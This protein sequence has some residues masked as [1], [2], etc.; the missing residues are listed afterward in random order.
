MADVVLNSLGVQTWA[1]SFTSVGLNGRWVT[2]ADV[3]L[4]VIT[5]LNANKI[6][7]L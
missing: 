2:F 4:N 7:W 5:L 6:N 1:N 3:K